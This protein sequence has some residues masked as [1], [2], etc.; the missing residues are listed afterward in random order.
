MF[1]EQPDGDPHGEC[2]AEIYRLMADLAAAQRELA[3]RKD[4][5][6]SLV[7]IVGGAY[8]YY[9]ARFGVSNKTCSVLS[10]IIDDMDK[11]EHRVAEL[12]A[13]E[14]VPAQPQ[15][16]EPTIED[17]LE[18]IRANAERAPIE[19]LGTVRNSVLQALKQLGF[20]RK[21]QP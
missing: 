7:R 10:R 20:V 9:K 12:L 11:A 19:Q 5:A 15:Y 6:V 14:G 2:A 13:Q 1:D 4:Y 17:A 21:V 8:L 16:R 18:L 3:V